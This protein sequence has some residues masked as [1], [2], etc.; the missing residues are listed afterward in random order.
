MSAF[1]HTT[2]SYINDYSTILALTACHMV[3]MAKCNRILSKY[4]VRGM[5]ERERRFFSN[6]QW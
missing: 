4:S 1:I 5:C 6:L 3:Y 2:T